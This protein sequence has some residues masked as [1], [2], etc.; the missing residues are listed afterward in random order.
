MEQNL[1][2]DVLGVSFDQ[3]SLKEAVGRGVQW[4]EDTSCRTFRYIVTPNPEFIL[5]AEKNETFRRCLNQ[6]DLVVPD[7]IGVVYASRI[8]GTPLKERVP[9]IDVAWGILEHL[10]T[11]GG[12]LF[13]MGAKE[14][15]AEKAKERLCEKYPNL[16][17]CGTY[18]GYFKEED[19]ESVAQ[20]VAESGADVLFLCLGAPRQELFLAKW[21]QTCGVQIGMGLGGA[22][23]VFAGN[24]N[25]AP[26]LWQKLN[27][28]WLYRLV[29]EPSR[30]QRMAKLPLVLVQAWKKRLCGTGEKG[31]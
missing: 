17:V 25:R 7:G 8:L 23:D 24:V 31:K 19:E 4:L 20:M 11:S 22:L 10:H 15:V 6:A 27:A 13:L 2:I 28:E 9:G 21:G 16:Q 12:R 18:H 5:A 30:F 26:L 14:G 3:V 1:K 29:K